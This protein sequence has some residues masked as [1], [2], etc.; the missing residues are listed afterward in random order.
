M[1]ASLLALIGVLSASQTILPNDSIEKGE[2]LYREAME[3]ESKTPPDTT[4]AV[5]LYKLSAE[6]GYVPAMRYLGFLLY[7]GK[8]STHNAEQGI[9]WLKKAAE[10]GDAASWEN[11]GWIY[12]HGAENEKSDRLAFEAFTQAAMTG[13]PESAFELAMMVEK[14]EG[15]E[16]DTLSAI[17]Y[18]EKALQGNHRSADAA[19]A[20]LTD[21]R[22][23][24]IS[25]DSAL[26]LSKKYFYGRAPQ[27]GTTILFRLL[28]SQ[29]AATPALIAE[30]KAILAQA[31][32]LGRG[33]DY[34]PD[35]SIDLYYQAANEG[36]PSAQ[37]VI[38]EL[39]ES[40]PDALDCIIDR[41]AIEPSEK[42][43]QKDSS[44]W[45]T[46]AARAGVTTAEE[47]DKRLQ[48][49]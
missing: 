15:T 22:M 34:N 42:E 30:C 9:A 27:A 47:A 8:G 39:L 40:F 33:A 24:R 6:T 19:L 49:P 20:G 45:R 37:F 44:Y 31:I 35:L 25:S 2:A 1:I 41:Q 28:Q 48:Q 10:K 29:P 23:T 38:A 21:W 16:C 17:R 4:A 36:D 32:S 46:L 3:L 26:R 5:K 13:R 7:G 11:L 12:R 43:N 18:Y 14:G